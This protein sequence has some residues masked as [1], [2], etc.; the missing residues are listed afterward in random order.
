MYLGNTIKVSSEVTS[1]L[2][3]GVCLYNSF[4]FYF[5]KL[6]ERPLSIKVYNNHEICPRCLKEL[7]FFDLILSL[8]FSIRYWQPR[9]F[10]C[11]VFAQWKFKISQTYFIETSPRDFPLQSELIRGKK[12]GLREHNQQNTAGSFNESLRAKNDHQSY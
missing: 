12:F 5:K 9:S 8:G 11:K 6:S 2:K 3:K 1:F 7:R 10:C 4:N